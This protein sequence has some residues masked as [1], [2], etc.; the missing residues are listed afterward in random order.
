MYRYRGRTEA[1]KEAS[2]SKPARKHVEA[3][4]MRAGVPR[5]RKTERRRDR[6][7][8]RHRDREER[9]RE[10]ERERETGGRDRDRNVEELAVDT[11]ALRV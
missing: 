3:F 9:K 11:F 1:R 8:E 10:R 5:D 7:R 6:E 2:G 4:E